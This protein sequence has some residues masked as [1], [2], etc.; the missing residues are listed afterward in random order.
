ML[1]SGILSTKP[2]DK[3]NAQVQGSGQIQYVGSPI[4]NF[5]ITGTGSLLQTLGCY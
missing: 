3:L 5:S 2:M 4:L 1:G